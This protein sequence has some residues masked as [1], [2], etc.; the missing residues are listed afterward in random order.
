MISMWQVFTIADPAADVSSKRCSNKTVLRSVILE[1]SFNYF[2]LRAPFF[3]NYIMNY[4]LR[5][6]LNSLY[7]FTGCK[8]TK[9]I[10]TLP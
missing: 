9:Q 7:F 4:C 1:S 6:I 10:T 5:F 8:Q 2:I 3:V